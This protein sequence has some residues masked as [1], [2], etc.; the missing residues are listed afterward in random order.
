[1]T[2]GGKDRVYFL[3]RATEE[4]DMVRKA[5]DPDAAAIHKRLA[6]LYLDRAEATVEQDEK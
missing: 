3:K 1:M 2:A 5:K 6:R 4:L